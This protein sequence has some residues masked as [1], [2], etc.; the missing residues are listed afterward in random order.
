MITTDPSE[1]YAVKEKLEAKGFKVDEAE[2]EMIPQTLI[3]CDEETSKS[4][5]ALIEWLEDLED[6]N[7]VYH[8]LDL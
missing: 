4:N 5:M 7:A 1:L 3:E 2:I 6:V 8:N